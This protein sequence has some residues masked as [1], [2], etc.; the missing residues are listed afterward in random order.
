MTI[1][2]PNLLWFLLV[3][4]SVALNK[5]NDLNDRRARLSSQL[6]TL[7]HENRKFVAQVENN[8][9]QELRAAFSNWNY[10]RQQF[11]SARLA[12]YMPNRNDRDHNRRQGTA[13]TKVYA[14]QTEAVRQAVA[15]C[16]A[17][18][19]DVAV[20]AGQGHIELKR[21]GDEF[22]RPPK[23]DLQSNENYVR[24][25]QLE[26]SLTEEFATLTNQLR[27]SEEERQKAWK[28]MARSKAE[29]EG[30]VGRTVDYG[31]MPLPSLRQHKVD[32][33]GTPMTMSLPID[34]SRVSRPTTTSTA[35]RSS[36]SGSRGP[37]PSSDS[38]YSA[39]R[40]KERIASDGSVAPVTAPKRTKDGLFVRP[41]GRTRKG[42]EWD[43]VRGI[44]V[45]EHV[46]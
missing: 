1:R 35:S 23:P 24:N 2:G 27:I 19:V 10:R 44:W 17:D 12:S 11:E 40:V 29:F 38:K 8:Y 31:L 45:P 20:A 14:H 39:A 26:K 42:M 16:V 32:I 5:S 37:P 34:G 6:T 18:I 4:F 25:R 3:S 15:F 41:A 9:N 28:R 43:A 21:F 36:H 13:L 7:V 22:R 46:F 30:S 33:P